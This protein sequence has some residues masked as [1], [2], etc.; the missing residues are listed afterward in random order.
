MQA[1]LLALRAGLYYAVNE[2]LAPAVC[3]MAAGV[4]LPA[5]LAPALPPVPSIAGMLHVRSSRLPRSLGALSA[6]AA[7]VPPNPDL[8]HALSHQTVRVVRGRR[9][10][11]CTH[12]CRKPALKL[13]RFERYAASAARW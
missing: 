5:V 12:A 1:R 10:H 9:T 11:F 3:V 6:R 8:T 13:R 7:A 2:L 4:D